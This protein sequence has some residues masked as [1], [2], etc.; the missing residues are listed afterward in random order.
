M[1]IINSF[2]E[3]NTV[4]VILGSL[5]LLAIT[6]FLVIY[7][8]QKL[9]ELDI[10]FTT[11]MQG[12]TAF[13][14]ASGSLLEFWPNI[15]GY[16][17]SYEQDLDGRRWVIPD[18]NEK[19]CLDS[20]FRNS[21]WGTRTIQKWLWKSYG[22]RFVSIWPAIKKLQFKIDR[23]ELLE[24]SRA[25]GLTLQQRVVESEHIDEPV[26]GLL[27]IAPRPVYVPA[28]ELA[29]DNSK[30]DL[31]LLCVYQQVIPALS[32]IYLRGDFYPLLDAAIKAA[33]VDMG[34]THRV[35]VFKKDF[36]RE[37]YEKDGFAG[38][39]C[40]QT[41]DEREQFMKWY[42]LDYDKY[43]KP[44]PLTYSHWLRLAQSGPKSAIERQIRTLNFSPE[45]YSEL[46]GNETKSAKKELTDFIDSVTNNAFKK[47]SEA[48][49]PS[50]AV[51]QHIPGGIVQR[52]GFMLKSVRL[53]DRAPDESTIDLAKALLAKETAF[54]T[55]E[56]VRAEAVGER[57][58]LNLVGSGEGSRFN[59][60]VSAL[61]NQGVNPDLA[62]DVV[63]TMLRTENI[64]KSNLTTYVEGG[65]ST[66]PSI[67][68][69]PDLKEG[70]R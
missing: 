69:N 41:D 38:D 14:M 31:L 37:G 61:I 19:T 9:G 6:G 59:A 10:L 40:P 21:M 32:V 13:I 64:G 67:L 22:V 60:T 8:I 70:D 52:F 44:A 12:T 56:G 30:V 27:F 65:S 35:A 23:R 29:G 50:E 18:D 66:P 28:V 53:V 15:G 5:A 62:A 45:F 36:K 58:R 54:H 68:V 1:E 43:C 63:R 42:G 20:F 55:A 25:A 51:R 34:A 48:P 39:F 24:G 57:D 4:L 46:W 26:S 3:E 11:I 17:K 7:I 47:A 33:M 2:I 49:S 16:R